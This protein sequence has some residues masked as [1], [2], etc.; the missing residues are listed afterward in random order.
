MAEGNPSTGLFPISNS[1]RW[2]LVAL[3]FV[4]SF[5]NYLDRAT[6]SVA[7]PILSLDLHLG[8]E[9]KGLVL[10]S[11]FWSYAAM[12]IPVG[13]CADR[14]NLRWLYAGLFAVWSL[15]CG[16]TGFAGSLLV[17]ILLRIL[18]GVGESIYLPGGTKIVEHALLLRGARLSLRPVRQWHAPGP[19]GGGAGHCGAD[20]ALRMA[21]H[22]RR[23]G[24]HRH[25]L[26][27]ALAA[28][29]APESA[30]CAR[31]SPATAAPPAPGPRF[32]LNRNLLGICLGFFCFDYYW[33]LFVTWLPDYLVTV[34][35]LT[36]VRAGFY[37]ALPYLIFGVCEPLGGWISERSSAAVTMRRARAKP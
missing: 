27:G 3:L 36:L 29:R 7:L 12:Q 10:S 22:V 11:F 24:I 17:L 32:H 23:G 5:I 28:C 8:P 2:M 19:G 1:R 18:L 21:A 26:G 9:T 35:H 30:R 20:C 4:A 25:H 37:A 6:I 34:R 14:W 13:W 16:L 15:A 31:A 33:Y